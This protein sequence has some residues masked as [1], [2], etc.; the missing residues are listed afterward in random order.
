MKTGKMFFVDVIVVLAALAAIFLCG[1][2]YEQI[3]YPVSTPKTRTS[4]V[5]EVQTD[6]VVKNAQNHGVN[7]FCFADTPM[8]FAARD[9][10]L[11]SST[12]VSDR[13]AVY[14]EIDIDVAPANE[15]VIVS[16]EE[17]KCFGDVDVYD[18]RRDL[19]ISFFILLI[20]T[21]TLGGVLIWYIWRKQ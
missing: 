11:I 3:G 6:S 4:F 20:C 18:P 17:V 10:G 9:D 7:L 5:F 1:Y 15:V 14:H 8:I 16:G 12:Q 2:L 13:Y 21:I 19:I